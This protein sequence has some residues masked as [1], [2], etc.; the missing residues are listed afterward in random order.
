M[1]IVSAL[2][3]IICWCLNLTYF[4]QNITCCL[5]YK[6]FSN[7]DYYQWCIDYQWN[8]WV[9]SKSQPMWSAYH[10]RKA[11]GMTSFL[12]YSGY[13]QFWTGLSVVTVLLKD[14]YC[15]ILVGNYWLHILISHSL[16]HHPMFIV[17]LTEVCRYF[18]NTFWKWHDAKQLLLV[19]FLMGFNGWWLLQYNMNGIEWD[20]VFIWL[21]F[22]P[23][24]YMS[25]NLLINW[26]W[27]IMKDLSTEQAGKSFYFCL[28]RT[29]LI[30]NESW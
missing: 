22:I 15:I 10:A 21:C 30:G 25:F 6:E 24:R 28:T 14:G 8:S 13:F 1:L 2:L 17:L 5:F 12:T 18:V 7:D 23:M 11:F 27:A 4:R 29:C 20:L 26:I 3:D 19:C 16:M 9:V